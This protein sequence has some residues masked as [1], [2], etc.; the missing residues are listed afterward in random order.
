LDRIVRGRA[1]I[2]ILGILLAGIVAMQVEVLKLSASVGR[3]IE[4]STALQ[5]RNEQLRASVSALN[6]EQ[7]I[8]QLAAGMGMVMPDP[9]AVDFLTL[10]PGVT[11]RQALNNIHPPDASG[12]IASLPAADSL[13]ASP[14]AAGG[15]APAIAP[16]AGGA[17]AT[18]ATTQQT[19]S[20]GAAS[21]STGG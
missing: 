16:A 15:A 7:R 18:A 5:S 1:W 8:E 2:P 3:S 19:P 4:R 17:P 14:P 9:T 10:R 21:T 13:A 6:D 20:S 11:V 12:F